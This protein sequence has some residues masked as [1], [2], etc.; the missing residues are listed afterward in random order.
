M[1]TDTIHIRS[2]FRQVKS[3]AR[4]FLKK[5]L[6]KNLVF[7]MAKILTAAFSSNKNKKKIKLKT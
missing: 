2:L 3:I 7:R 4:L 1:V 5:G 6:Y